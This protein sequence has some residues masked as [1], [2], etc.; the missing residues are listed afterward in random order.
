MLVFYAVFH[1]I[2]TIAWDR[3][4]IS[5]FRKKWLIRNEITCLR[6]SSWLVL[7]PIQNPAV[8]V[9]RVHVLNHYNPKKD[10]R[11]GL[12]LEWGVQKECETITPLWKSRGDA[13]FSMVLLFCLAGC[14]FKP[15]FI[16]PQDW[17]WLPSFPQAALKNA[18]IFSSHCWHMFQEWKSLCFLP[19]GKLCCVK[20]KFQ[21]NTSPRLINA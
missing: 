7:W 15:G 16:S 21:P 19:G 14:P 8:W 5:V 6:S 2:S 1:L 11:G 3:C 9:P 10:S 4:Y 17:S 20:P 18:G 12:G 13:P